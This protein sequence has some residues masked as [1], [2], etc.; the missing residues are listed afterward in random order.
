MSVKIF[1]DA[2]SNLFKSILKEKNSDIF[3]MP[4]ALD[5]G[6]KK[7]LCYEDEIDVEEM[8][9]EFYTKMKEGLKPKTSLVNPGLFMELAEEEVKKGNEVIYVTLAESISGCY[10]SACMVASQLNE[11][12][13]REAIKIINSKTASFGEGMIALYAEQLAKNGKNLEEIYK[14]TL[15]YVDCV[16]SEFTVDSIKYLAQTGRVS[17]IAAAIANVLSIKPLL[18]GSEEGKIEVTSK[19]RGRL[20]ALR[21]I[22]NQV[23]EYIKDKVKKVI[24]AHCDALDDAKRIQVMLNEAGINDVEMYYYDLVTGAHVGPGTIAV[25][26][27]GEKRSFDK[28]GVI[29]SVLDKI[30]K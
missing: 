21:T 16:R 12:Y 15:D 17:K 22:A 6:N 7:Y 10:Q 26:Y 9:K 3:V 25:F 1:T 29:S 4:M 5:L 19:C 2:G 11:E 30:R 18:Y 13:K 24:I 8:S 27:E 28:K 23:I 14:E 20:N